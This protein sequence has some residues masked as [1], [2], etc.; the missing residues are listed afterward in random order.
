M[1]RNLTAVGAVLIGLTQ[2]S[3][4][5]AQGQAPGPG[6]PPADASLVER[7]DRDGNRRLDQSER[8]AARD[9]LDRQPRGGFGRRGGGPRGGFGPFGGRGLAEGSPG[10]RLN[11]ADVPSYGSDVHLYDTRALRTLFIQF[12][13]DDWEDELQ[14][15]YRTDVEVPASIVVDG[16]TY[17]DVG[18]RFRGQSSFAM[19]PAG[20]KRSLN[21][22]FDFVDEEQSL[23]GYRTL[24]L[25]NAANDPT[26]VR[27]VLYSAIARAYIPA[28]ALNYVRVVINGE[29]WGVF[30]SAQQY[31]KDF[32]RDYFNTTDGAR[33]HVPG[34]PGGRGGMEYRGDDPAV[35][36]TTYEIKSKD[37]DASWRSLIRLFKVLNE[38][39]LDQLEQALA[40]ILDIDGVLK[41]LALDVALANS[42]GYWARASD[43]SIYQDP[44]GRFH[45]IPHDMNEGIAEERGPGGRR[46]LPPGF[47]PPPGFQPPGGR[48]FGRFP[49]V[50]AELDPLVG[51]DD[52][53]KPLRSRLLAVPALR[54][55][56][57][58]YVRDIA[59]K[60]LDWKIVEPLVR[61]YQ[62]VIADEVKLDS[63]KLYS[64][65]AFTT[66]IDGPGDS[67]KTF[68][69]RR[70]RYLLAR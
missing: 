68:V 16:R 39:P 29:S 21:L 54:A 61:Q 65:E 64:T 38:T 5:T 49:E 14:A 56:Y 27:P 45:V 62:A 9:F 42:D 26:F 23:Y 63:R 17:R 25:L 52:P 6:F 33:W 67:L 59:E 10:R 66:D 15:F 7:F 19:V 8:R 11:P 70:R 69:E 22:S 57:L 44:Q 3:G 1:M 40:P 50:S 43:Y 51:L 53:T 48:G 58:A 36:K 24:N 4:A 55:K 31:N 20:L 60:H 34:S 2:L 41:F 37:A 32:L 47:T 35:Y 28:P 13:N 12:E 18:V 30:I 46:G